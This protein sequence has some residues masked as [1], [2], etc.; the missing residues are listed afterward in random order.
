MAI[1]SELASQLKEVED[2]KVALSFLAGQHS[3]AG[4]YDSAIRLWERILS[5]EPDNSNVM[6]ALALDLGR[7]A[8][9]NLRRADDESRAVDFASA[10]LDQIHR[11][12]GP[13]DSA[14]QTLLQLLTAQ[15]DHVA[16]LDRSLPPPRGSALYNEIY[17]PEVV[18]AAIS[19]ADAVGEDNL[20]DELLD[21]LAPGPDRLFIEAER[22]E[23]G[24]MNAEEKLAV[25][26]RVFDELTEERPQQLVVAAIR[27]AHIGVDRSDELST[28]VDRHIISSAHRDLVHAMAVAYHDFGSALPVLR[29]LSDVDVIAA[30]FL[31]E[32]FQK[33]N[34]VEEALSAAEAAADRFGDAEFALLRAQILSR[35]GRF[36]EALAAAGDL[37]ADPF[38]AGPLRPQ[39]HW[40]LARLAATKNEWEKIERHC[41]SAIATAAGE[42]FNPVVVWLLI[43]AQIKQ[44]A[45]DRASETV[46]RHEPDL[47]DSAK[48]RL[49]A[50]ALETQTMD[51]KL[52]SRMLDLAQEFKTDAE[53]SA[54]LLISIVRRTRGEGDEAGPVDSRS[55][56]PGDLRR[57]VFEEIESNVALN[58]SGS[59]MRILQ[60]SSTQDFIDAIVAEV[61][62]DD[63]PLLELTKKALRAQVPL[64]LLMTATSRS[65]AFGLVARILGVYV[66]GALESEDADADLE[67]AT[68]SLQHDVVV[69]S[70]ALLVSSLLADFG[71]L[72]GQF[73]RLLMPRVSRND[74]HNARTEI[75]G[76]ANSSG[77]MYW[78]TTEN[79]LVYADADVDHQIASHRRLAKLEE[80]VARTTSIV[81][82]SMP[83]FQK[84]SFEDDGAWLAPIELAKSHDV[85]LW[86]DE[87]AI[88]KL[89]REVGVRAFSTLSLLEYFAIRAIEEVSIDDVEAFDKL[90]RGRSETVRRALVQGIV[91]VPVIVEQLLELGEQT[92]FTLDLARATVGRTAWWIWTSSP[93]GDLLI[94]LTSVAALDRTLARNWRMI[95]MNAVGQLNSE[96]RSEIAHLLAAVAI[97]QLNDLIDGNAIADDVAAAERVASDLGIDDVRDHLP[98]AASALANYGLLDKP[99]DVVAAALAALYSRD[100][101]T[102]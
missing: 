67:T 18:I 52:A 12:S 17:R 74:V 69:D 90:D 40:L 16:I 101:T 19:A 27:L 86:S 42:A 5:L 65:Y 8:Q 36:D 6:T 20:A 23:T 4:D 11:W 13:T 34:R 61:R 79:R 10:A 15:N 99:E 54:A 43:E 31:V 2:D 44:G 3:D 62:Q 72:R 71:L 21:K 47:T 92:G 59:P 46:L 22:A 100:V 57:R 33:E 68:V 53:L 91:D 97:L 95:A 48:V 94:V 50:A 82:E 7:R 85:A 55:L 83:T 14:L 64:G 41:L 51:V 28:L 66:A 38:L 77:Q 24:T 75:N 88:R 87:V 89:A 45:Y 30:R 78:S 25:W 84:F 96:N 80:A 32:K 73:Q 60:A 26:E 56:I 63:Q 93:M 58:T 37:L 35:S 81:V 39:G 102:D 9:T 70:S 98:D 76:L 29:R 1:S 49:W